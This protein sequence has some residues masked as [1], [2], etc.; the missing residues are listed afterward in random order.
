MK[1]LK[2]GL[3]AVSFV[4]STSALGAVPTGATVNPR[5]LGTRAIVA[6][7]AVEKSCGVAS[8]SFPSGLSGLVPYGRPDVA[9]ATMFYP[10][11]DDADAVIARV[12]AGDTAQTAVDYVFTVD[13]YAD[14]R[15]L[16]A[17]KLD[18]D[19]T[20]TV[21]QR[22]GA[23]NAEHR[24]AVKGT[25]FVVQANNMLSPTICARM[26]MG[27]QRATG[28]L[29]QRLFAALKAGSKAGGDRNGERSGVVRVWSSEN[30]ATFYTR[31]LAEAVVHGSSHAEK[32]LEVELNRYQAS[33]AA[34]YA[35][36]LVVLDP[37]TAKA[38]KRVLSHLGYYTGRVDGTWNDA[39]DQALDAFNWNN[40]FFLKPTVV[41]D[42]KR[43]IDAPLAHF[44]LNADPDALKPATP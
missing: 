4:L 17:V 29:P 35:S 21:G 38:V 31:V 16:A 14:Y 30:E 25:T 19:G 33:V 34:P 12:D 27:F 43:R 39:A 26:A 37:E 36:D 7:D 20:I 15:Q 9:V 13:P 6:C 10:S 42:G 41:V 32:E 1:S 5:L 22:T 18:P 3:L 40:L 24:C 44:L 28:S 23:Q 11:V 8:L 2:R